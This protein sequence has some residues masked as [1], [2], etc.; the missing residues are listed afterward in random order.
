MVSAFYLSN[1]EQY[2]GKDGKIPAFMAN[3]ASLPIDDSSRF[4]STGPGGGGG[5]GGGGGMNNST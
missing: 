4:I 5:F 3:V 1:V 2:L